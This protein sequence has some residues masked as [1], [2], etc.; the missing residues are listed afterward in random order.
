MIA[1]AQDGE[2]LIRTGSQVATA[3]S[4]PSP[5]LCGGWKCIEP[6]GRAGRNPYKPHLVPHLLPPHNIPALLFRPRTSPEETDRAMDLTWM[7]VG[8]Q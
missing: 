8:Q 2:I 1:A 5:A 3:P 7:G 4:R 6:D